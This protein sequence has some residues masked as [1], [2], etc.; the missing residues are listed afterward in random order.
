MK[1]FDN[2]NEDSLYDYMCAICK[3]EIGK[4]MTD[5]ELQKKKENR[6]TSL[7]KKIIGK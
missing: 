6:L 4:V 3:K 1:R 7:I 5:K 2:G